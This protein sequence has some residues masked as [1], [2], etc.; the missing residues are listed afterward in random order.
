MDNQDVLIFRLFLKD[1]P[2]Q[3]EYDHVKMS[4]LFKVTVQFKT[5]GNGENEIVSHMAR[6]EVK[7]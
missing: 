4:N 2:N 5:E 7:L 3:E 1:D 6:P